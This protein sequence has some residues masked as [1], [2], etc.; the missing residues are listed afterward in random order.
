VEP[1]AQG[2]WGYL[3][4]R[5]ASF[6]LVLVVG[7]L[8]LVSLVLSAAL[9]AAGRLVAGPS[10][11]VLLQVANTAV[12][13]VV[14][15]VLFA[16]IFRYLPDTDVPWRDVWV[17]AALTSALFTL[18]K[19]FIGLY[20]GRSSFGSAYGAAGSLVIL[21]VWVYYA[22]QVFF[23]GAE[24]TQTFARRHGSRA[25]DSAARKEL[26]GRRF[27][28]TDSTNALR[29]EPEKVAKPVE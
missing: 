23:F 16:L 21:I 24:L 28:S 11:A 1:P 8:L 27:R 3:R 7:F 15:T 6:A 26:P 12:S 18:G 10:S 25:S 2:V 17:G 29:L 19:F 22:A 4:T 13:L 5:L 20:L 9:S 14:V